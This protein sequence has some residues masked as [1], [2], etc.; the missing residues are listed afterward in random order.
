[1]WGWERVVFR[2]IGV[3]SYR[4]RRKLNSTSKI[5]LLETRQDDQEYLDYIWL[6]S[7]SIAIDNWVE[8][9][10][11]GLSINEEGMRK[12]RWRDDAPPFF[13]FSKINSR[14]LIRVNIERKI[15]S[16]WTTTVLLF[17]LNTI[18]HFMFTTCT[19]DDTQTNT[20]CKYF[21]NPT[22]SEV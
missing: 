18:S 15:V 12:S 22:F 10:R 3:N 21:A 14:N 20:S 17:S 1:M 19:C 16:L 13:K 7:G 9:G 6:S 2:V 8:R 4:A 5:K 11:E